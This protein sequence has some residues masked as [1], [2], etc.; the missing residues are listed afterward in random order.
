VIASI[1]RTYE[2]LYGIPYVSNSWLLSIYYTR[3]GVTDRWLF[4]ANRPRATAPASSVEDSRQSSQTQ[5]QDCPTESQPS[6]PID[7]G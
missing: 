5:A 1:T 2:P 6:S 7:F 3:R 4:A